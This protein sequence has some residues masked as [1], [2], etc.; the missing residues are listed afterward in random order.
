[1][2]ITTLIIDLIVAAIL[3]Y[4]IVVA[5]VHGPLGM[6]LIIVLTCKLIEEIIKRYCKNRR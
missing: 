6:V 5:V 3:V 2:L 4:A 1:M